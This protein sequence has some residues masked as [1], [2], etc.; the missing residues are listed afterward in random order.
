MIFLIEGFYKKQNYPSVFYKICTD[1]KQSILISTLLENI[2]D[3]NN[4]FHDEVRNILD[5]ANISIDNIVYD[6]Y[7]WKIYYER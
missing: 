4:V 7:K 2:D 3:T 1:K 6:E 5:I